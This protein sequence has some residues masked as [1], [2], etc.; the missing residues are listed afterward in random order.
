IQELQKSTGTSVFSTEPGSSKSSSSSINTK[1]P[2]NGESPALL[3]PSPVIPRTEAHPNG[4]KNIKNR[5]PLPTDDRRTI[6]YVLD[7]DNTN[8]SGTVQR[9]AS[10][11]D[12]RSLENK[13]R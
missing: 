11:R 5:P 3:F 6:N 13:N 7:R 4:T 2:G 1:A 10:T 9:S 8:R 12:F